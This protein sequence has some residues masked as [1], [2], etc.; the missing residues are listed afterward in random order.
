M[1][2]IY[3]LAILA[4]AACTPQDQHSMAHLKPELVGQAAR[5]C[6]PSADGWV[7]IDCSN[8]AAARSSELNDWSRYYIQCGDD[9]Y[10]AWGGS[11]VTAD[12][13]DGYMPEGTW[14]PFITLDGANNY[15]S[16]LNVN[17]DSD[18]RIMECL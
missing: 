12:S 1:K 10:V 13:N 8:L 3:L 7:I 17:D 15:V 5:D 2:K 4:L 16:C 18:C 6:A 9:S 11:T 14:F